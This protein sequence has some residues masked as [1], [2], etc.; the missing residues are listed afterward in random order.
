MH[1]YTFYDACM[2]PMFLCIDGYIVVCK[3]LCAFL[4]IKYALC[5]MHYAL[6]IMHYALCIMYHALLWKG[7]Y[8]DKKCSIFIISKSS[9]RQVSGLS[10]TVYSSTLS[11]VPS[12][13]RGSRGLPNML[14]KLVKIIGNRAGQEDSRGEGH[15]STREMTIYEPRLPM[16]EVTF[17]RWKEVGRL[18]SA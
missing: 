5:N 8:A 11:N 9:F 3:G 1:T 10:S 4:F 6:C 2:Q 18:F 12:E 7:W 13:L 14:R 15:L 17:S 16:G